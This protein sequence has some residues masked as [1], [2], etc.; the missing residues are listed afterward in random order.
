MRGNDRE[1]RADSAPFIHIVRLGESFRVS[2]SVK[3]FAGYRLSDG[4]DGIYGGWEWN[5]SQLTIHQ[6]RYGIRPL[7]Y[8]ARGGE[9]CLAPSLFTLI[10]EGAPIDL[11]DAALAVFLRLGYFLGDDTPFSAIRALPPNASVQWTSNTVV[12]RGRSPL[13]KADTR[14]SRAQLV[15]GFIALFEEAIRRRPGPNGAVMVPLSGGRDS[16][17]I[18]LELRRIRRKV[19]CTVTFRRYPSKTDEDCVIAETLSAAVSTPHVALNPPTSPLEAEQHKNVVTQFLASEHTEYLPLVDYLVGRAAAVYDGLGGDVLSAGLFLDEQGLTLAAKG[20]VLGL[21][22]HLYSPSANAGLRGIL[23]RQAYRR[24]SQAAAEDRISTELSPHFDAANPVGS[25]VFWNRTRRQVALVPYA[26]LENIPLV[27]T[28]YLDWKLFDFL[29]SIPASLLVDHQ[30]H[31]DVIRQAYPEYAHIPFE[32]KRAGSTNHGFFRRLAMD[33]LR[34]LAER[35]NSQLLRYSYMLPRLAA[36]LADGAGARVWFVRTAVYL[37]QLEA[38]SV[39][40][41]GLLT[42]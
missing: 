26:M 35:R 22:R 20:D 2:G 8:F 30:L 24:F 38:L 21:A 16:R 31:T 34:H 28:P 25:F 27:Y 4:V 6:D 32:T 12:V 7:F 36:V 11:D 23:T 41:P 1:N 17:H 10:R 3:H 13:S 37:L 9:F 39:T 14:L 42:R 18:L 33:F 19:D 29:G 15:E 5:G 40:Q